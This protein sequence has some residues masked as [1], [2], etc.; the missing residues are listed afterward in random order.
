MPKLIKNK[1]KGAGARRESDFY[2]TPESFTEACI[3][4]ALASR[5]LGENNDILDI[6]TGDGRWIKAY[7]KYGV[8]PNYAVSHTG[9]DI[10]PEARGAFY[11][12]CN[13]WDTFLPCDFTLYVPELNDV[14]QVEWYAHT[15]EPDWDN[16]ATHVVANPPFRFATEAMVYGYHKMINTMVMLLPT[17][18]IHGSQ[19][20]F[21]FDELGMRPNVQIT[22]PRIDFTGQ[23]KPHTVCSLFMWEKGTRP[24]YTKVVAA[25]FSIRHEH[26]WSW[27]TQ[28]GYDTPRYDIGFLR[29]NHSVFDAIKPEGGIF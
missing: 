19:R 7:S 29:E 20:A 9:L 12:N 23:K 22:L 21:F 6:G 14:E 16:H 17:E 10:R 5:Y 2:P 1:E 25:P 26:V 27:E 24:A 11:K 13:A 15:M 8:E 3:A 18:F 28:P 4:F